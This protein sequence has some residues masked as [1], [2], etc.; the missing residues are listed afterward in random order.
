MNKLIEQF[1]KTPLP[2]KVAVLVLLVVGM[3]AGNYFG[4][5]SPLDDHIATL[6][7]K[8]SELDTEYAQK[9]TIA[10]KNTE[11]AQLR[12]DVPALVRVVNQL[13]LENQQLRDMHASPGA[14]IIPFPAR[15][16]ARPPRL[17]AHQEKACPRPAAPAPAAGTTPT[18]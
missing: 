8:Q 4:L 13:T 10:N 15:E 2:Q 14:S 12:V 9:K 7:R 3:S 17:T 1:Q 5:I 6:N 16:P 18:T 11:L